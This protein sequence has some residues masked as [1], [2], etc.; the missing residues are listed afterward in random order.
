M[1]YDEIAEDFGTDDG[2]LV[3][4]G[5][6]TVSGGV[7]I[8]GGS[9]ALDGAWTCALARVRQ[10]SARKA[11]KLWFST[12][13]EI[14]RDPTG[15]P[16]LFAF[17]GGAGGGD[18]TGAYLDPTPDG[19]GLYRV[20]ALSGPTGS[21]ATDTT[22]GTY[23]IALNTQFLLEGIFRDEG[24]DGV[25]Y[26]V[27]IDGTLDITHR[28]TTRSLDPSAYRVTARGGL[29]SLGKYVWEVEWDNMRCWSGVD[30]E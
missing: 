11:N 24:S 26:E 1:S 2:V 30:P 13:C 22:N 23:Q 12:L 5:A 19:G 7:L 28:L 8:G 9:T 16:E 4:S 17:Q 21:A 29:V 15:A 27:W 6:M 3:S 18:Q 14:I 10:G 25:F 20:S